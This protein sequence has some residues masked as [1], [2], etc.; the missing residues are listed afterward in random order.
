MSPFMEPSME[1]PSALSHRKATSSA[2]TVRGIC[3]EPIE[4]AHLFTNPDG[5]AFLEKLVNFDKIMGR[6]YALQQTFSHVLT[7]KEHMYRYPIPWREREMMSIPWWT[8]QENLAGFLTRKPW[9]KMNPIHGISQD[10]RP[11]RRSGSRCV[12]FS[13]KHHSVSGFDLKIDRLYKP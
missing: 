2:G 9:G 5:V 4:P 13:Q 10:E 8:H 3:D 11:W 12:F 1:K 7:S 6:Q